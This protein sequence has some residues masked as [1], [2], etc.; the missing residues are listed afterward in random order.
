MQVQEVEIEIVEKKDWNKKKLSQVNVNP[1][2]RK[3]CP[4]SWLENQQLSA[5][6]QILSWD[7]LPPTGEEQLSLLKEH[8]K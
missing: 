6:D 4:L 7:L 8:Q 2:K 1:P 3:A 5:C